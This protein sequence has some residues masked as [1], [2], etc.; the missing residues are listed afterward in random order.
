MGTKLEAL[1][2]FAEAKGGLSAKMRASMKA[3]IPSMKAKILPDDPENVKKLKDAIE[4]ILGIEV[5]S[6]CGGEDEKSTIGAGS[7]A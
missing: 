1:F 7:K 5:P 3:V 4:A 6:D 2:K